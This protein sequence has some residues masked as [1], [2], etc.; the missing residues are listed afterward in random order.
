MGEGVS[1]TGI[2]RR[3]MLALS[4]IGCLIFRNQVG[5][6]KLADGRWLS[7]GLCVGSSDLIGLTPLTVTEDMVGKTVA[8]FTAVEIKTDRGRL[9][10]SQSN[11]LAAIIAVGGIGVVAKSP[12]DAVSAV[13]KFKP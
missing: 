8:V 11:F 3:A 5:K 13:S 6:Y 7:S 10:D 9:E 1:E 4:D 2:M 12:D